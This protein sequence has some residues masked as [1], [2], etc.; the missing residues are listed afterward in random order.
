M[1]PLKKATE[2]AFDRIKEAFEKVAKDEAGNLR[3]VQE[4]MITSTD[5]LRRIAPVGGQG[6]VQSP[7]CARIVT[8]SRW[9]T[10]FGGSQGEKTHNLVVC[11]LWRKNDWKEPNRL[12]VVQTSESV[13]QANIF[14]A[15][16]VRQG[17]RGNLINALT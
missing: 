13:N 3:T 12:L 1:L 6:G 17:L 2:W 15:H 9:Q 4:I 14:K 10:T 8:V 16:A 11:D 5:Y 7:T